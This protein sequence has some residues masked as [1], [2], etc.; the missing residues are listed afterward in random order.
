MTD[1]KLQVPGADEATRVKRGQVLRVN[2]C[3]LVVT[4]VTRRGDA[5]WLVEGRVDGAVVEVEM[6]VGL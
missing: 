1:R 5:E 4:R 6:T 3:E 2:G